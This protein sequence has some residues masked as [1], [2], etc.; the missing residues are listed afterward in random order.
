MSSSL[1]NL[2]TPAQALEIMPAEILRYFVLRSLP[3]RVIF[4]DPG[5]GLY[6]LI[7]EFSKLEEAVYTDQH[8]EFEQAYHVAT[9]IRGERTIARIAF[10][11]LVAVYQTA[12]G[13]IES[14]REILIRTGYRAVV[15]DQWLVI[16]RE[17]KFVANWL[18]KFA[19]ESVKF[20]ILTNLPSLELSDAQKAFLVGLAET[21]KAEKNL[22][23]QGMHDA[24]YAA[25]MSYD[26]KAGQAFTT[27]YQVLLGQSSGP[28]A[29]WFL[30]SL[31][32]D[33]LVQRLLLKS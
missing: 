27:L 12:Q 6:N 23:G 3:K 31:D 26:L 7:D 18:D 33:W 15:S 14:C 29:G 19:P 1:G 20:S 28:K 4:F 22:N 8:P 5:L 17:L 24:I 13:D 32:P 16:A 25:A 21:I 2:V 11:H 9:A 30:A 10:S